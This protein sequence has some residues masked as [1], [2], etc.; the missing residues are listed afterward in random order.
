VLVITYLM[1]IISTLTAACRGTVILEH[2]RFVGVG[3][4]ASEDVWQHVSF[5]RQNRSLRAPLGTRV[6]RAVYDRDGGRE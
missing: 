2:D 1:V 4:W 6:P 5:S 3:F